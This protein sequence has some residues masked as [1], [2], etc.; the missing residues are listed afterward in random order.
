MYQIRSKNENIFYN[1]LKY[2]DSNSFYC[3]HT[4]FNKSVYNANETFLCY[5]VIYQRWSGLDYFL[6]WSSLEAQ[7]NIWLPLK[8]Q[9]IFAKVWLFY[10]NCKHS[11]FD[12]ELR[13]D[14]YTLMEQP[15]NHWKH[16]GNPLWQVSI[17]NSNQWYF[18]P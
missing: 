12:R 17:K 5:L 2:V 10:I 11:V 1:T 9:Q 8:M 15:E 3:N 18:Q 6:L 16:F 13:C 4:S 7:Q 14:H